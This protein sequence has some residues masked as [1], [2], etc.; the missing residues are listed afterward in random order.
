VLTKCGT[1]CPT[2]FPA[3]CALGAAFN[4]KLVRP[5]SPRRVRSCVCV[6]ASRSI[7][8]VGVT[9]YVDPQDG[10]GH[11]QRSACA[12]QRG[13]RW[14]RLLGAQHQVLDPAHKQDKTRIPSI[15][16]CFLSLTDQLRNAM[17]CISINRD[18][19]WGRNMEVPIPGIASALCH[20]F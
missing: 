18:P 10:E 17:V 9:L 12:Q 4:M 6:R 11:F 14:A 7:H 19:R 5:W 1:N 2:S 15:R 16:F 13:H 20:E 3:P 8:G